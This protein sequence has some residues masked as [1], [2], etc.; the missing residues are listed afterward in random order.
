MKLP[1]VLIALLAL[2]GVGLAPVPDP[3]VILISIDGLMAST[4]NSPG[5][6]RIP[7]LRALAA[8]GASA[9]GVV[10][11]LPSET[12][13]SHTT[14]MTGVSPAVHGIYANGMFDPEGRT[15]GAWHWYGSEIR[16]PTL[17]GAAKSRGLR[18][19]AISWPV[20]VGSDIDY[21]VPEF[22]RAGFGAD[23]LESLLL[24][25]AISTPNLID[26]MEI[27][28]RKP[29]TPRQTDA[30]RTDMASIILRTYQPHLMLL[31]LTELDSAQ[32]KSGP[33]SPGA[34][35]TLER[36]DGYVASLVQTVADA[37]IRDSTYFAI[38]SDHGFLPIGTQLQPN[39]LFRQEKLLET[40]AA[41]RIVNWQAYYD[42][43]GGSGFIFLKD[44]SDTALATRVRS[45]LDQLKADPANG[46]QTL[47]TREDLDRI[48]AFPGASFG[49]GMRPNFYTGRGTDQLLLKTPMG[50][51]HG[52]DPQ[53]P[54]LHSSLI[55]SA[56]A[57]GRRGPLGVV[58]MTQIAPTVAR[59]L[60]VGLSPQADQ[61]IE[62]LLPQ[63]GR[64]SQ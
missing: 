23:H 52:F 14:L 32:H 51:G 11:V 5:P 63:S 60:G 45:L 1:R 64:R 21:H 35:E 26:T 53:L 38:V 6:A 58:R 20:T 40:D 28:R 33:G 43:C 10:G 7:T 22:W 15:S 39:A 16:V 54:A 55:V 49:I 56:P 61:P 48:G 9:E 57:I 42:A 62:A 18:T 34:I 37:G 27:A 59:W 3:H 17:L 36:I 2:A 19:S 4:Y 8:G 30:D 46:I 31:H 25:R 12:Y 13:P 41:G 29:F 47:W 24:L 50:G 44:P